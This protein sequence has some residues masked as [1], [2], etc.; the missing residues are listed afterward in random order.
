MLLTPDELQPDNK[1]RARQN[2]IHEIGFFQ[3][4]VGFKRVALVTQEGVEGFSNVAGVI[5]ITFKDRHIDMAFEPL[6]RW[7]KREQLI[8]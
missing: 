8:R 2:V 7:L 1:A 5:P 3:A 6:R 4:A